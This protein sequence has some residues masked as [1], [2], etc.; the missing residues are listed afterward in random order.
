MAG[1]YRERVKRVLDIALVLIASLPV[2][3]VVL[4][5]AL[6]VARDGA[7]PFFVQDRVGR[8]GKSFR[9]WKIR[10]MVPDAQ[11][12][13]E[14]HLAADPVARAEWDRNQKLRHDPRITGFGRMLRRS[15]LDELPQFL[16][17]LRGDMALVGPRPMLPS[18]RSFYPGTEYYALRPGVTGFW[19]TSVR[20]ESSFVDR[21]GFDRS[22]FHALS[23]GTDLRVLLRTLRVVV[24]GTG[25]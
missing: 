21:A 17:V 23:L 2:A 15:S 14:Q 4:L 24:R 11:Q 9:M 13:L 7:S 19:Q 22:Y 12:V 18:Q 3:C 1:L 6:I 16:N 8:G 10:T 5:L 20:N 25:L